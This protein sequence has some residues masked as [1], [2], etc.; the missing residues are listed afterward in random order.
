MPIINSTFRVLDGFPQESNR[1]RAQ[2][3]IDWFKDR[4]E[5]GFMLIDLPIDADR[6]IRPESDVDLSLSSELP[7]HSFRSD[8]D[9][10]CD[11]IDLMIADIR[12]QLDD[13]LKDTSFH[14]ISIHCSE[15]N[16]GDDDPSEI[17]SLVPD[18]TVGFHTD[19]GSERILLAFGDV[20]QTE[21]VLGAIE[22]DS[23]D[24]NWKEQDD[25]IDQATRS[26]VV[27]G[28]ASIHP[29]PNAIPVLM[30]EDTIHQRGK[31]LC[32]G[33]RLLLVLRFKED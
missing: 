3:I 1:S 27:G 7:E 12:S 33:F 26:A 31:I 5:N 22:V 19:F 8:I 25:V 23:L 16:V 10:I 18:P 30:S 29:I 2:E 21:C 28:H 24:D 15:H 6:I 20:A 4:L 11:R 13:K 9:Y 14:S 32:K 17:D